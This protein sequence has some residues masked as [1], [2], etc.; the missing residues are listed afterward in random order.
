MIK[1]IKVFIAGVLALCFLLVGKTKAQSIIK[2]DAVDNQSQRMVFQQWDQNKFYPKKGFLSLNP[3][4]WLV[5]GLF[6]PSYHNTD[7]RP[8]SAAGPQTQRLGLV[9]AMSGI[10][11]R[12]KLQSDTAK[13][14]ALSGIA[15]TSG[16]LSD[17]DPLWILYYKHQFNP[18]LNYSTA[19]ILGGLS[20]QVSSKLQ[21]E[22]LFNWYTA[23]LDR[24]KE[25]LNGAR[26]ADMDRGS[27]ILAY[28]RML[29]EYKT[30]SGVWAV[31]TSAA[32]KTL[33]M[34]SHRGAL[35]K[36]N[37]TIPN[38]TPGSDV[39]IAKRVLANAKY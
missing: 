20:M 17:T 31:R 2:D 33:D 30:L 35:Q 5:W 10:D 32:Q 3:Y 21:S 8:L 6:D 12:Y 16:L 9:A 24:L 26:S 25:R 7:K 37:V 36:G 19:S 14:T 13:N 11:D 39:E 15:E 18:L 22:G 34:A 27:R 1:T 38:W 28:Y 4:Y 23:E 29:S